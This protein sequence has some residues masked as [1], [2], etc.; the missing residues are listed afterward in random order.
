MAEHQRWNLV[1]C[2]EDGGGLRRHFTRAHFLT[3]TG[4]TAPHS[5]WVC[6]TGATGWSV[7]EIFRGNDDCSTQ[8][9]AKEQ[10]EEWLLKAMDD[11]AMTIEDGV[12]V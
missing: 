11:W 9:E 3:V 8:A 12:K 4:G 2:R 1:W 6:R 7:H 10:A 5:W